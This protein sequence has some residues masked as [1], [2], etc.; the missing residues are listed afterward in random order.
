MFIHS[1]AKLTTELFRTCFT[2]T[3]IS[4]TLGFALF[5]LQYQLFQAWFSV[6]ARQEQ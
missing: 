2:T 3:A 6:E 4:N 1:L 5:V